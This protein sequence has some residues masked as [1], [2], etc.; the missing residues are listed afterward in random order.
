MIFSFCSAP[1]YVAGAF[2]AHLNRIGARIRQE[3]KP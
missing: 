1:A 2:T 3:I